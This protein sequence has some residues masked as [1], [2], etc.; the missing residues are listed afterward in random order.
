MRHDAVPGADRPLF[1]GLIGRRPWP[2]DRRVTRRIACREALD[3]G[4][5]GGLVV[6]KFQP[7]RPV[8]KFLRP[9]IAAGEAG[10]RIETLAGDIAERLIAHGRGEDALTWLDRATDRHDS[11]A[12]RHVDLRLAALDALGRKAAAQE[13]RL[14]AFR[15]WLSVAHLR[16]YLRGLADFD[17]VEAEDQAMAHALSHSDRHRALAL[18]I[19]WPNLEA[20]NRLVR[21]H[22]DAF[23]GRDY[24]TLR[25]AAEA[26]A[27]KYPAAATLLHRALAEDVLRRAASRQYQYAA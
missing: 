17:D 6:L 10:G 25:P 12:V 24:G 15:R 21:A 22:H 4:A 11:E 1:F 2:D 18:L 27:A 7:P 3:I 23:D 26:L 14:Q 5:V 19:D 13:L 20:A 8:P 16:P 9:F